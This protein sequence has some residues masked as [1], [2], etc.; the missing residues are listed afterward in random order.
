[1]ESVSCLK[2]R[3]GNVTRKLHKKKEIKKPTTL[4][5]FVL[6]SNV[7]FHHYVEFVVYVVL[8]F[9]VRS[10]Q[11]ITILSLMLCTL[12]TFH[13]YFVRSFCFMFVVYALLHFHVRSL[14][15][16]T[17]FCSQVSMLYFFVCSLHFATILCLYFQFL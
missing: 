13:R 17:I 10:L 5:S 12:F 16:D 3:Y 8:L 15:F 7:A 9:Y 11:I 14:H 1:M 2:Q 4:I 6:I